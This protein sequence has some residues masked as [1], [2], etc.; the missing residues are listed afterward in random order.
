MAKTTTQKEP[1]ASSSVVDVPVV[2]AANDSWIS[3]LEGHRTYIVCVTGIL[4]SILWM[5]KVINDEMAIQFLSL[6]GFSGMGALRAS[7]KNP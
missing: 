1:I 2:L 4:F 6:L 7:K 3:F 5:F